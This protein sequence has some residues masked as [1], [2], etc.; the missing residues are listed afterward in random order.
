[1]C[2]VVCDADRYC[3]GLAGLLPEGDPLQ[4]AQAESVYCLLEDI[5]Q[6]RVV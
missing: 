3:A 5:W 2:G 4:V 6:V 1:M